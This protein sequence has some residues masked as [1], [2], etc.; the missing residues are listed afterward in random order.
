MRTCVY[1][2]SSTRHWDI[3]VSAWNCI[4][5]SSSNRKS[6]PTG[7]AVC[8][9]NTSNSFYFTLT[10]SIIAVSHYFQHTMSKIL[11][12]YSMYILK[13]LQLDKGQS[14]LIRSVPSRTISEL[15]LYLLNSIL[16]IYITLTSEIILYCCIIGKNYTLGAF[17]IALL[18]FFIYHLSLLLFSTHVYPMK[19]ESGSNT[20]QRWVI[21]VWGLS[22]AVTIRRLQIKSLWSLNQWRSYLIKIISHNCNLF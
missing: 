8:A 10:L 20:A 18:Y 15:R 5:L 17:V 14:Q 6:A 22:V 9:I 13:W 11:N 19:H 4:I 16:S 3:S 21:E 12:M 1:S 2:W 7:S